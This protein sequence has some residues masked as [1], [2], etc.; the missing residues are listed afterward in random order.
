M[1][2]DKKQSESSA[3]LPADKP[4]RVAA[5]CRTGNYEKRKYHY[6]KQI[7]NSSNWEFV[8]LY[9]DEGIKSREQFTV[10]LAEAKTGKFDFIITKNV[11]RFCGNVIECVSILMELHQLNPPIGVYFES[12]RLNTLELPPETGLTL[13][14]INMEDERRMRSESAKLSWYLRKKHGLC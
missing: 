8:R 13:L 5:Y 6:Q 2:P 7:E 14:A 9:L 3:L 11:S 10:M 12:E 1:N 4:I